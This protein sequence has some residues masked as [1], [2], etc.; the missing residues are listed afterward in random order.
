LQIEEWPLDAK[1]KLQ[2]PRASLGV[3]SS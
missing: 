3:Y 1:R 2:I